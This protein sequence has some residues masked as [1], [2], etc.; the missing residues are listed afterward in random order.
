[1]QMVQIP[2]AHA[3]DFEIKSTRI[4]PYQFACVCSLAM[5]NN[6]E[7]QKK[8]SRCAG[9]ASFQQ[10]AFEKKNG[11]VSVDSRVSFLFVFAMPRHAS[12]RLMLLERAFLEHGTVESSDKKLL[13]RLR[14][15]KISFIQ[16][17]VA[18][19]PAQL[20]DAEHFV[21][22]DNGEDL[23]ERNNGWVDIA[24][25]IYYGR[26]TQQQ[27]DAA[28]IAWMC[29]RSTPSPLF[30]PTLSLE[31]IQ[32]Q[33]NQ[34]K[35]ASVQ[36]SMLLH[37][38]GTQYGDRSTDAIALV[39]QSNQWCALNSCQHR[40]PVLRLDAPQPIIQVV[41]EEAL[42]GV[43]DLARIVVDFLVAS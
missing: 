41:S 10:L 3:I 18:Y 43:T 34:L 27:M 29:D 8:N 22:R 33:V 12:S 40:H 15:H 28:L 32:A 36:T 20:G 19:E 13:A 1:M 39:L 2:I 9:A 38:V 11:G 4:F 14:R 35:S 6:E 16:T 5:T 26:I 24:E 17:V 42:S 25:L 31:Q 21:P 30:D 37:T 23:V 7:G